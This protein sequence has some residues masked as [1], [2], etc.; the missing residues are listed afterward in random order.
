[1][2]DDGS[3][4]TQDLPLKDPLPLVRLLTTSYI[5]MLAIGG[6]IALYQGA[7]PER[8]V[9]EAPVRDLL[10]GLG[11]GIGLILLSWCMAIVVRPLREIIPEL[12]AIFKE[13]SPPR[14]VLFAV[15]VGCAEEILFRGV[16]QPAIGLVATSLA[17]GLIHI[18]PTLKL[19]PWTL[20]AIAAGFLLGWLYETTGG[21]LAP[22][23]AHILVN[24]TNLLLIS[25]K[26]GRRLTES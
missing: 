20:F 21:L 1:V 10:L 11:T 14:I 2:R 15:L 16:L 6:S 24:G 17:F 3:D 19:L 26:P 13:L 5:A 4:P 9:G 23:L 7:L 25:R 12:Q 8:I 22:T 18:F